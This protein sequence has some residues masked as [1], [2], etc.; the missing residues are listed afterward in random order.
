MTNRSMTAA[1][2]SAPFRTSVHLAWTGI[3]A[4]LCLAG[5]TSGD[6]HPP[7]LFAE[8]GK[9][10]MNPIH[11]EGGSCGEK[12]SEAPCWRHEY[13][14]VPAP[15]L[16]DNLGD[17]EEDVRNRP[18]SSFYWQYS[19]DRWHEFSGGSFHDHAE[20][21]YPSGTVRATNFLN[22]EAGVSTLHEVSAEYRRTDTW[23][24]VPCYDA[25]ACP[26]RPRQI[27][28]RPSGIMRVVSDATVGRQVGDYAFA[29]GEAES[30]L[31]SAL[32]GRTIVNIPATLISAIAHVKRMEDH[33]ARAMRLTATGEQA[34][35]A[36]VQRAGVTVEGSTNRD[37]AGVDSGIGAAQSSATV[38]LAPWEGVTADVVEAMISN[39][40][41]TTTRATSGENSGPENESQGVVDAGARFVLEVSSQ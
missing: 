2:G 23:E 20:I 26:P 6:D 29:D 17:P 13:R 16:P 21:A 35:N 31:H 34:A 4:S 8:C 9:W 19:L 1:R 39:R 28:V 11:D 33:S 7:A 3:L 15:I 41:R 10:M 22:I 37:D 27:S 25:V 36:G 18:E 5:V 24:W 40:V 30:R 32:N 38:T 12:I 14:I